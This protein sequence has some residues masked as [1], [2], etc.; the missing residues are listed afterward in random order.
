MIFKYRDL[1][2]NFLF[3]LPEEYKEFCVLSISEIEIE[4]PFSELLVLN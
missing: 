4:I 3:Y 2:E 1:L